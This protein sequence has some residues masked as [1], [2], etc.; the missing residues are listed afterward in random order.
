M[1]EQPKNPPTFVALSSKHGLGHLEWTEIE[2]G[3]FGP[4][5]QPYPCLQD[6]SRG[7]R[8]ERWARAFLT[9]CDRLQEELEQPPGRYTPYQESPDTRDT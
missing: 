3:I 7:E 8:G 2:I 6:T 4:L 9:F 5:L 1:K